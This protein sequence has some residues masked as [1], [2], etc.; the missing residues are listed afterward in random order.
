MASLRWVAIASRWLAI[1]SGGFALVG[2]GII[3][4]LPDDSP[5][6]S[7]ALDG[8]DE[9]SADAGAVVVEAAS[10]APIDAPPVVIARDQAGPSWMQL[11]DNAV[12]WHNAG[13]ALDGGGAGN[14]EI[15]TYAR[16][17]DAGPRVI[18][19][20]LFNSRDLTLDDTTVYWVDTNGPTGFVAASVSH[21]GKTGAGLGQFSAGSYSARA[22]AVDATQYFFLDAYGGVWHGSKSSGAGGQLVGND[23]STVWI[24]AA[25]ASLY[26]IHP[27][28]I[29]ILAKDG[30]GGPMVFAPN[31]TD[32]IA[33]AADATN[34]Y[35]ITDPGGTV[36]ALS[37][38]TPGMTP[39]VLAKG[40]QGP[41][42]IALS[43]SY[44]YWTSAGDD[45]VKRVPKGG[46]KVET[47]LSGLHDPNAIAVDTADRAIYFTQ[48]IDGTVLAKPLP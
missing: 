5:L 2:C 1:A 38:T 22:V 30:T 40:Q 34:L 8:G 9:G 33:M 27:G 37:L 32:P 29:S 12:Y 48:A 4:G 16:A 23:T 47:L 17:L 41:T 10:D 46:G 6:D 45:T 19:S 26:I 35:W 11:D 39:T 15:V 43:T 7:S 21:I 3:L 36:M 42:G 31:Q 25:G 18:A 24:L 20:G 14:G 44:V 28:V 13:N